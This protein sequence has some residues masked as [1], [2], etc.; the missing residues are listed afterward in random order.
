MTDWMVSGSF[1]LYVPTTE[2][3]SR[4][5]FMWHPMLVWWGWLLYYMSAYIQRV[6]FLEASGAGHQPVL[7]SQEWEWFSSW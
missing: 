7:P 3:Q 1:N 5:L 4:H 2:K 6:E